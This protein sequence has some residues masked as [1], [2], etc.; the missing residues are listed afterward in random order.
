MAVR[1][2]IFRGK[3]IDNGE[4]VEGFV[5]LEYGVIN[6]AEMPKYKGKDVGND[7]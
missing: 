3:R 4:W 7:E 2:I 1:T 6:W 5:E